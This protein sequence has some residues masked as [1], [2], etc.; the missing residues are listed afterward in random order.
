MFLKKNFK[1]LIR[2]RRSTAELRIAAMRNAAIIFC[3]QDS[4]ADQSFYILKFIFFLL[5]KYDRITAINSQF[6][7]VI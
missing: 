7:G 5:I 1:I 4:F 2:F 6:G 3:K